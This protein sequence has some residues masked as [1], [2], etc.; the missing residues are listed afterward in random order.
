MAMAKVLV[1]FREDVF[2]KTVDG[3]EV[4][5]VEAETKEGAVEAAREMIDDDH[6]E[7]VRI[8]VLGWSTSV[9]DE[10]ALQPFREKG[11]CE[12]C[13]MVCS[14]RDPHHIFARGMGGGGRL[15]L[16]T[17]LVG[18]CR[19]CHDKAHS[20]EI[21]KSALVLVVAKRESIKAS[22]VID[23]ITWSR[24]GNHERT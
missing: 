5:V 14:W 10:S 24:G 21:T 20:G 1:H 6:V 13:G 22:D 3:E 19:P 4:V 18:L 12:W 7:I 2:Q 17:N 9:T 16:K 8:E 15:D 11:P 23:A